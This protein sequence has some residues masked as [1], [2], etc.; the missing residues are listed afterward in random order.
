MLKNLQAEMKRNGISNADLQAILSCSPKT[1][2]NKLNAHTPLSIWDAIKIRD[3]FFPSMD[4]EYLFSKE[5][6]PQPEAGIRDS[7]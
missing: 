3:T 2:T 7:A 6:S 1:V 4:L 5:P